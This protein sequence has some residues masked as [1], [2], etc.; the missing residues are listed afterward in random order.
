MRHS[1]PT[2]RCLQM[3]VVALVAALLLAESA[4]ARPGGGG[5]GG[6]RGGRGGATPGGR[7]PGAGPSSPGRGPSS[8][9]PGSPGR[10]PGATPRNDGPGPGAPGRPGDPR[11]AAGPGGPRDVDGFLGTKP[12][13]TATD[14]RTTAAKDRATSLQQSLAG[15]EEPFTPSWYAEHPNAWQYTHPNAEWWAVA[16]TVGLSQWLG[17]AAI[18][19][20]T[21]GGSSTTVVESGTAA[22]TTEETAAE[23]KEQA[24]APPD[25]LDWLPLGVFASSPEGAAQAHVYQQLAVSRKGEIK[26]NYY[27]AVSDSVQPISG[28]IDKESRVAAWTIGSGKGARFETTIDDLS[29]NPCPA[30]MTSGARE[31]K[32]E[33]VPMEKPEAPPA[34]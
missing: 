11:P 22:A 32:W 3:V 28:R 29:A 34:K 12:K 21:S 20:A 15:R 2:L 19:G 31:Q 23:E 33:L 27:D 5:G 1:L 17:Y 9:G 14:A 13:A 7:G 18:A 26:G 4:S 10:S 8:P 25:D 30:T 24:A 16:G 6:G